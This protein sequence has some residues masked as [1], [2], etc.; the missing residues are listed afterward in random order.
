[1]HAFNVR[2]KTKPVRGKPGPP[3][4]GGSFNDITPRSD[5]FGETGHLSDGEGNSSDSDAARLL[6]WI[7]RC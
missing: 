4:V 2:V 1:M 7:G 6:F 3:G 5:A